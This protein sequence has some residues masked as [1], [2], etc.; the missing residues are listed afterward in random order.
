[1]VETT[2]RCIHVRHLVRAMVAVVICG[3]TVAVTGCGGEVASG[4]RAN[5][6][7]AGAPSIGTHSV[8]VDLQHADGFIRF[9][10]PAVGISGRYPVGWHRARALTNLVS[11]REVVAFATYPLRDGAEAGECAPDTAR[12]DMPPGG[13]FIWLLEYRPLLGDVWADLPRDR[14]PP[15]P[16]PFE[17]RRADLSG[18]NVSCFSGPAAY[19]T[20]FRMADRPFQMLVAFGGWPRDERLREVKTILDS[21]RFEELPSLPPDPYAGWPLVNDNPGDSLRPPPGWPATAAMFPVGKTPRPRPLFFA[22][23]R[24]LSGLPQK[25]LAQVG[26]LPG[27]FPARALAGFPPD[28]VLVWAL[29]EEK[30][31]PSAQFPQIGRVW[32]ARNDFEQ[33]EAPVASQALRWLRAGGSFHG[34]R[35]SVWV[36]KGPEASDAD[37]ALGLKSAES[38]AVSGCWRERFDDCP[39]G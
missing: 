37:L 39:D 32:P 6:E 2:R 8:P 22:G 24:P 29:E 27:P 9:D 1:M 21:L 15:K 36:A 7:P 19:S 31:G 30:G 18:E 4:H 28:G 38:L 26:E 16:N 35:F 34:Y 11:P 3:A 13:A 10:D 25:L 5:K 12:A 23:N 20:T 17:I 14:F 33:A